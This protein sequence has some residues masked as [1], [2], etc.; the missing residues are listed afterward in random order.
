MIP[1]YE[2][3]TSG[4][5]DDKITPF[6][7]NENND[8]SLDYSDGDDGNTQ[9]NYEVNSEKDSAGDSLS[10]SGSYSPNAGQLQEDHQSLE[11]GTY[12]PL[13]VEIDNQV[14][15]AQNDVQQED[16]H[17]PNDQGVPNRP[18]EDLVDHAEHDMCDDSES[19]LGSY[20]V[21]SDD[22]ADGGDQQEE[23][24]SSGAEYDMSSSEGDT[25]DEED[26]L[27]GVE[28][29]RV[30]Y[31]LRQENPVLPDTVTALQTEAGGKVYVIGTAHFSEKSQQDVAEVVIYKSQTQPVLNS[32]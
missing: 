30:K 24:L 21:N 14:D 18:V 5:S 32:L 4:A 19:D 12:R 3:L 8:E 16:N 10:E 1:T 22:E 27:S 25:Y 13:S 11:E 23:S 29:L 7:M 17:G 26:E 31:N 2:N 6:E 20:H 9:G 28:L 15:G